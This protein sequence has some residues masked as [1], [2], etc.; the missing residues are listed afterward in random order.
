[1]EIG[2]DSVGQRYEKNKNSVSE[3]RETRR[4]ISEES[5]T[6]SDEFASLQEL[7]GMIDSLDDDIVDSVR[8]LETVQT[9]E[10]ERLESEQEQADAEKDKIT[11]D[12][13]AEIDKLDKGVSKLDQL[14]NFEFGQKSVDAAEKTYQTEI[15]AFKE[16]LDELDDEIDSSI[17]GRGVESTIDSGV[18]ERSADN[19]NNWAENDIV[20]LH[21]S[22][23]LA[24]T[25]STPRDLPATEYGFTDDGNG[26][27]VYDS[28][29]EMAQFLY[30]SQGSAYDNIKGTCG[31]CSVANV[32]R[33]SGVNIGEK[34]VIDYAMTEKGLVEYDPYNPDAS[35]G[36]GPQ[37]RQTILEHFG[38]SSGIF[39]VKMNNG[40]ASQ[41]TINEIANHIADGRGV[42]LSVHA[43]YLYYGRSMNDDYHAVTVSSV[44]KDSKGI[45]SGFYIA[46]SN[47][48]TKYYSAQQIQNALTGNAM[49]VTYSH[50]R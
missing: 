2:G 24:P 45:V 32:L 28:P 13:N 50:I 17:E 42:I 49:N 6:L 40:V 18:L 8:E 44:V 31:L 10:T 38:I 36:T 34:E 14:R 30:A 3:N 16:L 5:K 35:G 29:L 7:S 1:M 20:S 41:E 33:L 15:S 27:Q 39:P 37:S 47:T 9:T 46:D 25:R 21:G 11:A 12:I 43:D 23:N 48:G 26:N 4:R 19:A 22:N